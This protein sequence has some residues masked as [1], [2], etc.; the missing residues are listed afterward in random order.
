MAMSEKNG[1]PYTKA[2]QE[3]RRRQVYEMHFEKS[4]SAMKIAETLGVSRN[5]ISEDIKYWYSELA[6]EFD[7]MEVRGLLLNQ[8]SR[9]EAQ[10]IRLEK[11]LEK[12]QDVSIILKIE[13]M[14]FELDCAI[15]KIIAPIAAAQESIPESEA[16]E[17]I[18]HLLVQDEIGKAMVY[19][20]WYLLQ[21]IIRYKKC[22]AGHAK[23]I[24]DKIKGLGLGFFRNQHVLDG[25]TSYDLLGF[26]EARNIIPSEKLQQ[27]YSKIEQR[28]EE[29]RQEIA[30]MQRQDEE[31][32]KKRY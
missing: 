32:E 13:R 9:M 18:E 30:E 6:A 8:H 20:D 7:K 11:M 1:G 19:S 12:Q 2:E 16:T 15:A 27:I 10:R 28:Q 14:I 3:K 5:T 22:D 4:M 23:K 29:Q 24:L 31:L 21:D 25:G 26:A 17:T